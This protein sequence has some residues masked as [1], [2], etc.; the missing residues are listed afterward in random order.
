MRQNQVWGNS[1]VVSSQ[2][3]QWC[4]RGEYIP[5]NQEVTKII[6]ILIE[7]SAN[8]VILTTMTLYIVTSCEN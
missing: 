5:Y 2:Y 6:N 1:A 7:K 4:L 3:F 8:Y